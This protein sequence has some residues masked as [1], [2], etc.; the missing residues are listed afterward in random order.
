MSK[1]AEIRKMLEA[2]STEYEWD[3]D[4]T[5]IEWK[6]GNPLT[7]TYRHIAMTE[8]LVSTNF[9]NPNHE[10]DAMFIAKA[11]EYILHLLSLIEEKDK[12]LEFYANDANW[13][14]D[15]LGDGLIGDGGETARVALKSTKEE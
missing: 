7:G 4:G 13:H 3:T 15:Q 10:N 11:P 12:A 14:Y 2:A 8:A 9:K 1:L 5:S 6:D